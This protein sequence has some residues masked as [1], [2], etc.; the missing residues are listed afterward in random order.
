MNAIGKDRHLARDL[1]NYEIS[2]LISCRFAGL[3]H[4]SI[5]TSRHER[6]GRVKMTS[7]IVVAEL[8]E[9]PVVGRVWIA[10]TGVHIDDVLHLGVRHIA[11]AARPPDVV[12]QPTRMGIGAHANWR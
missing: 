11:L 1:F 6:I 5:Q 3:L 9:V 4:R 8:D 10:S 7:A 12:A 2:S